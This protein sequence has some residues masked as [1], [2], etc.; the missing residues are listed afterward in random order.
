[1]LGAFMQQE[2]VSPQTAAR[3]LDLPILATAEFKP[4][5]R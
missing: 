4:R 5:A 1:L 3:D 2:T